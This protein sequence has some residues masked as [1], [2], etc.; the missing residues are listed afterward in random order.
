[1]IVEKSIRQA[2]NPDQK[3][4]DAWEFMKWWTSAETSAEYGNRI[5]MAI[6]PVARYTT[7]NIEA[8]ELL[9]WT[10][11]ESNAIKAQREYVREIPELVGGYYVARSI[12]NAFRNV[13]NNYTNPREM[14]FYYNDQMNDEIWRKRIEYNLSVPEEA[15][16]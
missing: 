14:L 10:M 11:E 16:K 8:F 2:K 1:M 6:G 4:S 7:A 5:E 15:N 13:T 9:N 12:V 3:R